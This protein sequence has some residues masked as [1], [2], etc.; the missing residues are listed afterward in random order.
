MTQ[1]ADLCSHVIAPQS[2]TKGNRT[3]RR[4][5]CGNKKTNRAAH[6]ALTDRGFGLK[7]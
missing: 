2:H 1:A 7:Q 6:A 4:H 3:E 5:A